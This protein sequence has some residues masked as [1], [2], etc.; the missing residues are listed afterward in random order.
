MDKKK[1]YLILCP[2]LI[3]LWLFP[4]LY[5]G[6]SADAGFIRSAAACPL[7]LAALLLCRLLP[8]RHAALLCVPAVGAGICFLLPSAVYDV[9]PALLLCGWLRCWRENEKGNSVRAY[10]EVYTDLIYA[11][12]AAAVIRL[13]RY[14]YSFIRIE[15]ADFQTVPDLC[16]MA[17]VFLACAAAF[18]F[19]AGD[20]ARSSAAVKG[21]KKTERRAEKRIVGLIPVSVSL[22]TFWAFAALLLAVCLAQYTDSRLIAENNLFFRSGFRLLFFPWMALL[23]LVLDEFL[24]K[25]AFGKRFSLT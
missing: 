10:L 8:N 6:L 12:L 16:L 25:S 4:L 23:F 13:I 21:N 2:V 3:V 15:R 19:R 1:T 5:S 22:R 14:G 17:L 18:I 24:P 20:K 9:L 11:Y 7:S